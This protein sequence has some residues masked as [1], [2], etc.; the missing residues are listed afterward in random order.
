[1][2]Y[3]PL[4]IPKE[5]KS[6]KD[7]KLS[8]LISQIPSDCIFNKNIAGIGATYLEIMNRLRN[9]IIIV[10]YVPVIN[11]KVKFHKQSQKI[12]GVT[13]KVDVK[14]IVNYLKNENIYPKKLMTT[15]ESFYK[16][17]DAM[18]LLGID[19]YNDYF[20]MF[21]ECD[22]ITTDVDFRSSIVNPM[23]EFFKFKNKAF[24][25]ATALQ[26]SDPRFRDFTF[27]EL[28]P[29][30][31]YSQPLKLIAT[32]NPPEVLKAEIEK[33]FADDSC[34]QIFVFF[35]TIHG[36]LTFIE[37]N[38][39]ADDSAVFC[40]KINAD[41]IKSKT[42]LQLNMYDNIDEKSLKRINF[43]TS[44]FYT[45]VDI[46]ADSSPHVFIL[47]DP[48]W[49]PHTMVDLYRDV[50]QIGGRIRN[51]VLKSFTFISSH[52]KRNFY[53]SE[54]DAREYL[55]LNKFA[56]K[57]IRD[58]KNTSIFEESKELIDD[59]LRR[60]PYATFMLNEHK[61]NYFMIDNYLLKNLVTSYYT[62]SNNWFREFQ[63]AELK[64]TFDVTFFISNA[65][66][67]SHYPRSLNLDRHSTTVEKVIEQILS[68]D[69]MDNDAEKLEMLSDLE[70]NYPVICEGYKI[71]GK[72]RLLKCKKSEKRILKE[73]ILHRQERGVYENFDFLNELELTLTV[74]Q[75]Y[76]EEKLR[77]IV[78]DLINKYDLAKTLQYIKF[79][80]RFYILKRT[81]KKLKVGESKKTGYQISEKIL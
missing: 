43:L 47:S 18:D 61:Q 17:I 68:A 2:R 3:H 49:F 76:P 6:I 77:S 23:N 30:C 27:Y 79:L 53:R 39:L 26:P 24:V 22:R 36:I 14:M 51:F 62:T 48:R 12:R 63:S 16:I 11:G 72:E 34:A 70:E 59:I 40:S 25:S 80:K 65:D 28:V 54:E 35:N 71:L 78:S 75:F 55:R 10:P 8:D 66:K 56:F 31:K 13:D 58:M 57:Q 42:G 69:E 64:K 81:T 29:K 9:S 45:A 44:R 32:N 7:I 41:R 4:Y 33:I 73:I 5:I 37:K 38:N 20:L 15:P 74:G 60:T 67:L 52:T 21:D 19:V 46:F 50:A 1:M